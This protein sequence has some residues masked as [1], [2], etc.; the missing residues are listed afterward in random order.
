M[1]QLVCEMCGSTDLIK[2]DGVFVCQSCGCKYSVEEAKK[3]MIEGTVEVQGTVKVDSSEELKNLYEVAR[4]AKDTD[5]VEQAITFYEQILM[6]DPHSWE[7]NF[8]TVYFKSWKC[9]VMDIEYAT[10]NVANSIYTTMQLIHDY[11]ESIEKQKEALNE[12]IFASE[13]IRK[14]LYTATENDAAGINWS[15]PGTN[16]RR[17]NYVGRSVE[18]SR[19]L[20]EIH[21]G[22]LEIYKDDVYNS[23]KIPFWKTIINLKESTLELSSGKWISIDMS[24]FVQLIKKHEPDYKSPSEMEKEQKYDSKNSNLNSSSGGCYVATA[25]YGSYDCPEVW[26]LRRYRDFTLAS[27]WYGRAFIRTYYAISPTIVRWFGNTEWF[28]KLWKGKL[29]YMVKFLQNKGFESTPY[30]DKY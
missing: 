2:S 18:I 9:K 30:K 6:K 23:V 5:N 14:M 12:M 1:K 29:D 20:Y 11:I 8:Y 15:E 7:A 25:V 13:K 3:M 26:T 19:I 24:E 10:K 28:K 22:L 21:R 27:T 4:R 16:D 17:K